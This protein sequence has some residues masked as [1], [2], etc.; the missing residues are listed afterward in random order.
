MVLR[1]LI[2]MML[3][4]ICWVTTAAATVRVMSAGTLSTAR[5]SHTATLLH[6]GKILVTG[7]YNGSTVYGSAELYNPQTGETQAIGTMSSPRFAHTATLMSNGKVLIAGG[8]SSLTGDARLSSTELFDPANNSF[9]PAHGMNLPRAMHAASLMKNGK[10]LITG[11]RSASPYTGIEIYYPSTNTFDMLDDIDI[12][13]A[14]H[15]STVRNDGKVLINS[16]L[17]TYLYDPDDNEA[18]DQWSAFSLTTYAQSAT[19]L[20]TGSVLL[21]GGHSAGTSREEYYL[22]G[23]SMNYMGIMGTRRSYHSSTLLPDGRVLICGG[24]NF[25]SSTVHSSCEAYT[26]SS[27]SFAAVATMLN[28]RYKHTATL[29]PGG[30]VVIIGGENA[31]GTA[32]QQI[33]V[34]DAYDAATSTTG[35][36]VTARAYHAMTLLADGRVLHNGGSNASGTLATSEIFN[37]QS[38]TYTATGAMTSRRTGHTSTLLQNGKVLVAGGGYTS[39]LPGFVYLDTAELFDPATG[40]YTAVPG[41]MTSARSSHTATLLSNGKVLLTG[42][43]NAG[44]TALSSAELF[45]PLTNS[46]TATGALSSARK[47]HRAII[48]ATGNVLFAGGVNASSQTLS[49]TELYNP[50]TGQFS[51]GNAMNS[52]RSSHAMTVTA[53]GRVLITGGYHSNALSSAEMYNP[54]SGMFYS[55]DS[56]L[57]ART[58]HTAVTLQNGKVLV[59]G[60]YDGSN[61]LDSTELFDPVAESFV[62]SA[63]MA[64]RRQ[65]LRS[66]LLADGRVL[67]SGGRSAATTY[68]GTSELFDPASTVPA[69]RLK[70]VI[71]EVSSS[72]A[73][74]ISFKGSTFTGDSEAGSGSTNS[75]SAAVPV[76]QLQKLDSGATV[77]ILPLSTINWSSTQFNLAESPLTTLVSGQYQ[78]TIAASGISSKAWTVQLM[79]LSSVSPATYNFGSVNSGSS[80]A[81]YLY[82]VSNPGLWSLSITGISVGGAYSAAFVKEDDT[83]SSTVLTPLSSCHFKLYF[84]PQ[85]AGA[86]SADIT[87]NSNSAAGPATAI[88]TGTGVAVYYTLTVTKY[89]TGNGTVTSDAGSISWNNNIG[90]AIYSSGRGVNLTATPQAGST[91]SNWGGDCSGFSCYLEMNANRSVTASF[92]M[93]DYVRL[94]TTAAIGATPYGT[95]NLA[96]TAAQ[97]GNVIRALARVFEDDLSL[98]R[99]V[100]VALQGG[101]VSGFGGSRSGSTTLNGTLTVGQGSLVVDGLVIK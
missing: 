80:S 41:S 94:G 79:P 29:L 31:S 11:G 66:V 5:S 44:S 101:Y 87:V 4:V 1:L 37:P 48:L 56:M 7:G 18:T 60:G 3:G 76:L 69:Q 27:N 91:F 30:K 45:D 49:S 54:V 95:L 70:P 51:A 40:D 74:V 97:D 13:M 39:G 75:S 65:Y 93:K 96:Y 84:R 100:N 64:N 89:G 23:S 22:Y 25:S 73:G 16:N 88:A 19:L 86:Q 72:A 12:E 15:T 68:V 46:F 36:M 81:A 35:A 99:A 26:Q 6:N 14:Q 43:Q 85:S 42:G 67:L 21:A 52:P 61:Y 2:G 90:T 58:N 32:L 55:V 33:E 57:T 98:D 28:A 50:T 63:A 83:C 8:F 20:P 82:T 24:I 71:T 92:I 59:A 47:D 17:K 38:S 62:T 53:G 78:A 34:I 9:T 77:A 10:V